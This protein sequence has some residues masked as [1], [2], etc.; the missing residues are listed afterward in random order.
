M[1]KALYLGLIKFLMGPYFKPGK[2]LLFWAND[3]IWGDC[4]EVNDWMNKL[5]PA[6]LH[7]VALNPPKKDKSPIKLAL[8]KQNSHSWLQ[9]ALYLWAVACWNRGLLDDVQFWESLKAKVDF[10]CKQT[11]FGYSIYMCLWKKNINMYVI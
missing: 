9:Q 6:L 7:L 10:L 3:Q 11:L 8:V 1:L 4:S 5:D 2:P